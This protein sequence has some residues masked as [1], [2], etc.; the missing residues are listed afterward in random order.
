MK[1]WITRLNSDL[2]GINL[3]ESQFSNLCNAGVLFYIQSI[4]YFSPA[5]PLFLA[6]QKYQYDQ[7]LILNII[8]RRRRKKRRRR[9][10]VL[11]DKVLAICAAVYRF[12]YNF[13][14][15]RGKMES[16]RK[17]LYVSD[18]RDLIV[19]LRTALSSASL[20]D[21]LGGGRKFL[22]HSERHFGSQISLKSIKHVPV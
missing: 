10:Y 6:H 7:I 18:A 1:Y 4:K 2:P 13:E 5:T 14:E 21:I 17:G 12:C 22:G 19:S 3:A 20:A 15:L 11:Q 9:R 8:G 16:S